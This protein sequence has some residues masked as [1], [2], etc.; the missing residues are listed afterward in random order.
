[1]LWLSGD[2]PGRAL[3]G[4]KRIT[5]GK[6]VMAKITPP[7]W[8]PHCQTWYSQA[9]VTKCRSFL[10]RPVTDRWKLSSQVWNDF[11]HTCEST[12]FFI[13][14]D[15]TKPST[16]SPGADSPASKFYCLMKLFFTLGT[17]HLHGTCSL[18][19]AFKTHWSVHLC[20]FWNPSSKRTNCY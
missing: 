4:S 15:A 13:T 10:C 3:P 14:P 8:T 18:L 16:K 2:T 12:S 20:P 17:P 6:R 1:M 11:I 9:D 5:G 7:L 19:E